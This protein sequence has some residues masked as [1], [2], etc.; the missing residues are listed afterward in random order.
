MPKFPEFE[1]PEADFR[2]IDLDQQ[3]AIIQAIPDQM[4]R[5]YIL[6][7]ARQMVRPS[8]TRA[9]FWEDV[10]FRHDRVT[11]RRHFS[12]NELRETTKS[13]RIKILP[14]HAEVRDSLQRLPHHIRSPFVFQKDGRPYSESYGRKLWNRVTAEKGIDIS[15]YQGTR[16]SSA[17]EAVSRVGMDVVQEFL[18]HTRRAMT[19]RYARIT[20]DSLRAVFPEKK[21]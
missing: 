13:K 11:I 12:L 20:V 3:D 8:E 1:I 14:L 21:G 6:F 15:L 9:L 19:K 17:T 18:G 5:A 4:D 16:H 10:D 7:T 2:T